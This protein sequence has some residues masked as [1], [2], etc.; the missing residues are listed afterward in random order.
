MLSVTPKTQFE[1]AAA[2]SSPTKPS[3]EE[4][5]GG[6]SACCLAADAV[7]IAGFPSTML[8]TVGTLLTS[9]E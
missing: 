2:R 1:H 8:V 3:K 4:Q 5:S 6:T 9:V 7:V